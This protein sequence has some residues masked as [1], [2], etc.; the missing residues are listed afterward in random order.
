MSGA[1]LIIL[2]CFEVKNSKNSFLIFIMF[3]RI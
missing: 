1:L 3:I 2:C